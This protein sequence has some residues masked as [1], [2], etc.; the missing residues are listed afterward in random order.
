MLYPIFAFGIPIFLCVLYCLFLGIRHYSTIPYLSFV[1]VIISG[2]LIVLSIQI[3]NEADR[4]GKQQNL[5]AVYGYNPSLLWTTLGIGIILFV[6]S[7][8]TVYKEWKTT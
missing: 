3:L 6:I 5:N 1:L 4:V 2:F 7:C 8:I